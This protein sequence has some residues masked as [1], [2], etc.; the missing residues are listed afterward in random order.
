MCC[1]LFL[2]MLS[3]S[4]IRYANLADSRDASI[5]IILFPAVANP[6]L[7]MRFLA[8]YF[9]TRAVQVG[10]AS[11]CYPEM[12][13]RSLYPSKRSLKLNTISYLLIQGVLGI[14]CPAYRVCKNRSRN[15]TLTL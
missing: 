8:Q 3:S 13:H 15:Y 14:H 12:V 10:Q 5:D 11:K 2:I 6:H 1:F 4:F 7:K 9:F